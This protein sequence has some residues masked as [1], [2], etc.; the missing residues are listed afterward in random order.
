MH[1]QFRKAKDSVKWP[2]NTVVLCFLLHFPS[3]NQ[4]PHLLKLIILVFNF[5]ISLLLM[6]GISV[7]GI[8]Y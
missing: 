8:L 3:Q 7:L 1:M 2:L 4:P 6:L 5:Y